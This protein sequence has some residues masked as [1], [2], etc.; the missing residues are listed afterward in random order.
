MDK[1]KVES[2]MLTKK[3][4]EPKKSIKK[5][6]IKNKTTTSK[7][8]TTKKNIKKKSKAFTLIELLAVIII[9]GILM[10]IAIPS[11]TTYISD[12]RKNSYI[13]TAKNLVGGARNIANEGKLGMY[14]TDTTY[15]LPASCI[16][17]EN[18]LKSP[19]GEFTEAYIGLTFDGKGYDYYWI[20]TDE[21]GQG[22]KE[23]T[24][25]DKLDI[26]K[27]EANLTDTEI[28]EK[29]DK[30]GIDERSKIQI[31]NNDCKSWGSPLI[32]SAQIGSDGKEI[33]KLAAEE[34]RTTGLNNNQLTS[35][36]D[37]NYIF[38]G[39]N[40]SNFVRF[41]NEMWR[42]VGVYGN[43][44]K[45]IRASSTR[46]D[47]VLNS[48]VVQHTWSQSEMHN[49][50]NNTYYNYMTASAKALI[51]ENA[52]WF[53]GEVAY[54]Q[55]A[56]EAYASSKN[57]TWIGK[58]GLLSSYEYM[59]GA[60]DP[61]CYEISGNSY[62]SSCVTN[63]WLA[64]SYNNFMWLMDPST[65]HW[66][67]GIHIILYTGTFRGD[68]NYSYPGNRG[69]VFPVVYLKSSVKVASGLGTSDNPYILE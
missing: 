38:K 60:S 31:L 4:V 41:N 43:S 63:D 11:V 50:L 40:P 67:Y 52:S 16:N 12:S 8:V 68:V 7:V 20:S 36:G 17:T 14:D 45:I 9:L 64:L 18:G 66:A 22:V 21:T 57:A 59:Y 15:Y 3:K 30:T 1:K 27:I 35:I 46:S 29:V 10:I 37:N 47:G 54:D 53:I 51:N 48:S 24:P 62:Y 44:L 69:D 5:K 33:I 19:Y 34:I 25:V 2:K 23:V 6:P 49:Y 65:N 42:I 39:G 13:D 32:A 55:K 61:N 28:K 56:G 26:D 58:V